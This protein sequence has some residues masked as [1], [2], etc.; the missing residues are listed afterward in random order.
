MFN[1]SSFTLFC[2][3]QTLFPLLKLL[4]SNV[5]EGSSKTEQY[6]LMRQKCCSYLAKNILQMAN[7]DEFK[8][9]GVEQLSGVYEELKK[10]IG[11]D[12]VVCRQ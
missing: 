1:N 9:L 6:K 7:N 8:S 5:M 10:S 12:I 2:S 4:D 11:A 3:E